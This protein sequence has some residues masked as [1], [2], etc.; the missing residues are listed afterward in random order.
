MPPAPKT[1]P[2]ELREVVR[3]LM[4]NGIALGALVLV[5]L[6]TGGSL[7]RFSGDRAAQPG[8]QPGPVLSLAQDDSAQATNGDVEESG[9][10]PDGL[11]VFPDDGSQAC[12]TTQIWAAFP[13]NGGI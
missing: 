7:W 9:G 1:S 12:P 4:K 8:G 6:L 13:G 3:R 5:L 2:S 11:S 10:W